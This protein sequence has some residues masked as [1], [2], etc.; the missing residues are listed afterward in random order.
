MDGFGS[1]SLPLWLSTQNKVG[2]GAG[3][4]TYTHPSS[5]R[6][7]VWNAYTLIECPKS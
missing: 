7:E 4:V 5:G 3:P 2:I 1:R 6:V